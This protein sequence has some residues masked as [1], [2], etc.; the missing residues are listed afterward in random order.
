M[1]GIV[2]SGE[3][4]SK[5]AG[6]AKKLFDLYGEHYKTAVVIAF[7]CLPIIFLEC[8][9]GLYQSGTDSKAGKVVCHLIAFLGLIFILGLYLHVTYEN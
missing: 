6:V 1:P 7:P 9:F 2:Y 4:K 3:Y 8:L 5:Y